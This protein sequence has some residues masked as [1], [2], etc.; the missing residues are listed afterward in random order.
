MKKISKILV[1][2][3]SLTLIISALAVFVYA[4]ESAEAAP[5]NYEA[6]LEYFET[7]NYLNATFDD[8][9]TLDEAF[10]SASDKVSVSG[11]VS[12]KSK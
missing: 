3:L 6:V 4:D 12:Y 2:L 9:D 10:A 5:Y 8:A 7:D 11:K 1:V